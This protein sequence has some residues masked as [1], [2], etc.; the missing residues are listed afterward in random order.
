[1]SGGASAASTVRRASRGGGSCVGSMKCQ[2]SARERRV[3]STGA[4][5]RFPICAIGLGN[6]SPLHPHD[7]RETRCSGAYAPALSSLIAF[8]A[9]SQGS[10]VVARCS[11]GTSR[12][13]NM[14]GMHV[15]VHGPLGGL[16]RVQLSGVR[17]ALRCVDTDSRF[18][19]RASPACC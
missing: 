13:A 18:G 9:G 10:Q 4:L 5:F 14:A 8:Y 11:T 2:T 19:L 15:R 6:P 16:P 1:L 7:A 12:M 17:D 3:E